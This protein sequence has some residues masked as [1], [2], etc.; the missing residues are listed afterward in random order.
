MQRVLLGLLLSVA[1]GYAGYA[2]EALSRSGA[3]GAALIGAAV[4][5]LGGWDW[6]ILLIAFFISSSLLSRYRGQEKASLAEKFAKGSRR[7][8]GQTMA[9]GGLGALLAIGSALH[10]HRLWLA[11]YVG[12]MATVNA[13]TWATEVGV[14][15]R[16][17]PRL[18]VNGQEV[19]V[20]TSGAVS[21]LGTFATLAG[22]L[23]IGLLAALLQLPWKGEEGG[24]P[25]WLL[26]LAG[27]LGGLGGSLFDSLLGATVQTIYYCDR[28]AKETERPV[29]RCGSETRR[30]RGWRWLDN[31]L[32][33]LISS[34][35][36]AA[37]AS[38]LAIGFL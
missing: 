30:L 10:P 17:K 21:W 16:T 34:T 13:D 37:V 5:G 7:D 31:D 33:N 3:V 32:V 24:G 4:F 19:E 26:L 8:L 29:H 9:N 23:F 38:G 14:L 2:K 36:G 20:G 18:I 28:C 1:I 27:L 22:G 25:A 35:V 12:A 15:S 11:A 6:G